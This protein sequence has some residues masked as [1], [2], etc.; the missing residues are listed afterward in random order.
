MQ[1][2]W[3]A[4]VLTNEQELYRFEG[5]N[6]PRIDYSQN[7]HIISLIE[8]RPTGI[9]ALLNEE[10]K[11]PIPSYT[12]F[13]TKVHNA[14]KANVDLLTPRSLQMPMKDE[15]GFVIR[16]FIGTVYYE[17]VNILDDNLINAQ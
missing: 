13:T 6:V 7:E 1:Q 16:H 17:T 10:S 5:L 4:T 15:D 2:L 8:S 12:C 9:F 14:W 11:L 3:N